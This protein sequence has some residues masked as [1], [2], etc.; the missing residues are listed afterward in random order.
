MDSSGASPVIE[1]SRRMMINHKGV[2]K[3][4]NRIQ[5]RMSGKRLQDYCSL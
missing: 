5:L 1:S 3:V 2:I 4:E